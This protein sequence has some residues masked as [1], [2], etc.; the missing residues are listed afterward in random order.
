MINELFTA[1][2]NYDEQRMG[3]I[4]KEIINILSDKKFTISDVET[5]FKQVMYELV[6]KM[7][8]DKNNLK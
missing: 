7:N 2:I 5:I 8:I 3:Y 1:N 6:F 4:V